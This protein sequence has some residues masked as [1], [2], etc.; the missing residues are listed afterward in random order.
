VDAEHGH[1]VLVI[2]RGAALA[3]FVAELA[4]PAR[5][6]TVVIEVLYGVLV[7]PFGPGLV[8]PT[9]FAR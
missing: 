8:E 5:V 3:P 9:R 2:M 4:L 7:G 1:P 6:P